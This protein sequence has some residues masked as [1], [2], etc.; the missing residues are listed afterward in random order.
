MVSPI[1]SVAAELVMQNIKEEIIKNKNLNVL[2]YHRYVDDPSW[3]SRKKIKY[4]LL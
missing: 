2:F 1:S 3:V 4:L